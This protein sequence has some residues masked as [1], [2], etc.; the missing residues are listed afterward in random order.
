MYIIRCTWRFLMNWHWQYKYESPT[1]LPDCFPAR[2]EIASSCAE[3]NFVQVRLELHPPR[4]SVP[5]L[6]YFPLI[7]RNIIVYLPLYTSVY[8]L[9]LDFIIINME[10]IASQMRN[11]YSQKN[12]EAHLVGALACALQ[13]TANSHC[14]L[15]VCASNPVFEYSVGDC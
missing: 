4:P 12:Q 5:L 15:N 2:L 10:P 11:H 3:R 13:K 14:K 8:V 7:V 6:P 1:C 9:Q